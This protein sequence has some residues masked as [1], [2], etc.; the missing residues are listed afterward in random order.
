V[1][2]YNISVRIDPS[3]AQQG[4]RQVEAALSRIEQRARSVTRLLAGV[5]AVHQVLRATQAIVQTA[6]AYTQLQNR[7]RVV[8]TS[9]AQLNVVQEQLFELSQRT[10]TEFAANVEMYSRLSLA[11]KDLG[12][13]AAE[14]LRFQETL[15]KAII[16]SGTSAQ[17]ARSG[18]FQLSQAMAKGRLDGDEL[19]SVLENI[20]VV[21]DVIAKGLGVTRGE[22]RRLGEQGKI[23]GDAILKSFSEART[24]IGARFGSAVPTVGQAFVVLGNSI[25]N[26]IGRIDTALGTSKYLSVLLQ[27]AARGLD[28]VGVAA[29]DRNVQFLTRRIDEVKQR[30]ATGRG[31]PM[32]A[33]SADLTRLQGL[34]AREQEVLNTLRADKA[35]AAAGL[36]AKGPRGN[37]PPSQEQERYGEILR[38]T[39]ADIDKE[40]ELL[41]LNASER[42]VIGRLLEVEEKLQRNKTPISGSDL[43]ALEGRLRTLQ[44][45]KELTDTVGAAFEATFKGMEDSIVSFAATGKFAFSDFANQ[46]VADLIRIATQ[47]YVTRPL[48]NAATGIANPLLAGLGSSSYSSGG[49][50]NTVTPS[51]FGFANGGQFQVGGS[52]G[53]DSQLVAFRASPNET[54]SVRRPDQVGSSRPVVNVYNNV[55][56]T[57]VQTRESTQPDGTPLLE[58]FISEVKREIGAGGFDSALGARFGSKPAQKRR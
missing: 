13:S 12:T 46:V 18:I 50:M 11:T 52:G 2:N 5:F 47:A 37:L 36:D 20:P 29:D 53:T 21:A 30:M 40:N 58:V 26:F 44:K 22:L 42:E 56:N 57:E 15:N 49:W 17:E 16:L 14:L 9:A 1:S 24:E 48:L 33:M 4:G 10:R 28:G 25:V 27:D 35:Q 3:G 23:T 6:D 31:D 45:I 39:N 32:G 54:V 8:T 7:L 38:R 34:L 43:D 41:R 19:R 51:L 55:G